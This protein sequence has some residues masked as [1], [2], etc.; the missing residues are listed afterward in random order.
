LSAP[1]RESLAKL[2]RAS[3]EGEVVRRAQALLELSKGRSKKE[4]AAQLL[5][6]RQN[7]ENWIK[8]FEAD[9]SEPL[10]E[11]LR[12]RPKPGAPDA[13]RRAAMELIGKVID[14]DPRGF[15]WASPN[16]TAGLLAKQLARENPSQDTASVDTVR[17]ALRQAGYVWKR[18]RYVL[19]RRA[20]NWRQSK[21]G[22]RG[23]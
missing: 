7:L 15:G 10:E 6:S 13:K 5:T 21:G 11:R 4:V 18:P 1:A 23:G 16:W 9:P 8:R 14:Q 19:A 3:P 2:W 20:P 12:A 22:S 17:V